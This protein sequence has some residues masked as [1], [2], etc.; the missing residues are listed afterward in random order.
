MA[1]CWSFEKIFPNRYRLVII[2]KVLGLGHET[3]ALWAPGY[4]S[5]RLR[6]IIQA[7]WYLNSNGVLR[8]E[9]TDHMVEI[10]DQIKCDALAHG[11][12][13]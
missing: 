13:I 12:D 5:S 2:D 7:A 4:E 3:R 1:L 11:F 6:D 8:V 9:L 10:L